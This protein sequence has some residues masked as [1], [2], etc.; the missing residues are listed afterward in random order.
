MLNALGRPCRVC[1][2]TYGEPCGR[3]GWRGRLCIDHAR[4]YCRIVDVRVRKLGDLSL[5]DVRAAGFPSTEAMLADWNAEHHMT[6]WGH[7][8][9]VESVAWVFVF[10]ISADA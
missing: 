10:E 5:A 4:V 9:L 2:A 7:H 6:T 1:V 3:P 8:R